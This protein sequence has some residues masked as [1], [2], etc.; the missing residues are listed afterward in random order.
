MNAKLVKT[1]VTM[2]M[3]PAP[4]LKE[5]LHVLAIQATAAME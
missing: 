4:T 2:V 1:I 3:Q 5:V